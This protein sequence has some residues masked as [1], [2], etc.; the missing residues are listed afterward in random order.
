[1]PDEPFR[2]EG[3]RE[4]RAYADEHMR[5]ESLPALQLALARGP[6]R[7]ALSLGCGDTTRFCVY[8]ISKPF[9]ASA[10][11]RLAD[12]EGFDLGTRVGDLVPDL[13]SCPVGGVRLNDVM[14]HMGGFPNATADLHHL[15][16]SRTRA[17]AIAEWELEWEPG[18]RFE[19]HAVSAHWVLATVVSTL[20]GGEHDVAFHRLVTASL[21][22]PHRI[23]GVTDP[24][25]YLAPVLP[26]DVSAEDAASWEGLLALGGQPGM[27]A[28]VPGAGC[29]MTAAEVADV[30][31]AFLSNSGGLWRADLLAQATSEVVD[32]YWDEYAG[33]TA[34]RSVGFAIAGATQDAVRR[35]FGRR[36]SPRAFGH[37]GAGGQIAW[38]D[39]ATGLSF[40]CLSNGLI[41]DPRRIEQFEVEISDLATACL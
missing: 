13:R 37:G 27:G 16:D 29:V 4:L 1:M 10:L 36:S 21:G 3:V 39:P 32:D 17:A 41:T 5:R 6:H 19:Y 25:D 33:V 7:L 2:A 11:W 9:F 34:N 28:G 40:S 12:S 22:L 18:S 20:T 8:S 30:Y 38:A 35:G 31:Q 23:L 26:S 14:S 24:S 15:R